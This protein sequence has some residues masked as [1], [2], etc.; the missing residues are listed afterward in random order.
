MA[1]GMRGGEKVPRLVLHPAQ[2]WRGIRDRLLRGC[3]APPPS[4]AGVL[5]F[6]LH[7]VPE[8]LIHDG[9]VQPRPS[10]VLVTDQAA[11]DRVGKQLVDL[12]ATEGQAALRATR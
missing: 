5:Q 7:P 9:V 2:E 12:A 10:L 3:P 6:R 1:L 4:G 8:V 11:V